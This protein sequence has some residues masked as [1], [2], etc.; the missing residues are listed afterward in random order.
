MLE[1]VSGLE[2]M[3]VVVELTLGYTPLRS[4]EVDKVEAYPNPRCRSV[5]DA[6]H[7]TL[8]LEIADQYMPSHVSILTT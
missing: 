7:D 2:A 8:R 1:F 5:A 6:K 4:R 3:Y